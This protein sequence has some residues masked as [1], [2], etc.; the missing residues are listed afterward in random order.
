[1]Q[2]ME[3]KK[4]WYKTLFHENAIPLDKK[5]QKEFPVTPP[6]PQNEEQDREGRKKKSM[7]VK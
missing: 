3:K 2:E 6:E 4:T 1:M 5:L 7:C